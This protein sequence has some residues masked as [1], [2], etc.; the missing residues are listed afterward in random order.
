MQGQ[1]GFFLRIP[2]GFLRAF[3]AAENEKISPGDASV[4]VYQQILPPTSKREAA[5]GNCCRS[6]GCYRERFCLASAKKLEPEIITEPSELELPAAVPGPQ[7]VTLILFP[8]GDDPVLRQMLPTRKMEVPRGK[9]LSSCR[10]RHP[11]SLA[12][13]ANPEIPSARLSEFR[14][15]VS[16]YST[17]LGRTVEKP[18][19]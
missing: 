11:S 1:Q 16:M 18:E 8:V 13:S 7:E 9:V 2:G 5:A 6:G 17:I 12:R 15:D 3:P 14:E 19:I 4:I 10:L